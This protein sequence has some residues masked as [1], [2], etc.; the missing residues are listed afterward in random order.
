MY[1]AHQNGI[2][3][4]DLKPAN[5]MIDERGEPYVMDFGLAK[6]LNDDKKLTRTGAIM[7]TILY[8]PPEQKVYIVRSINE[9]IFI[10]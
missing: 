6:T 2:I 1:Y 5:I 3:H 9:V 4:R 10:P 8:M 7:G